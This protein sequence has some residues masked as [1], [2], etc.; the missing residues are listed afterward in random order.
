MKDLSQFRQSN[1]Y[2]LCKFAQ[3]LNGLA[4]PTVLC[5]WAEV[6]KLQGLIHYIHFERTVYLK[7]VTVNTLHLFNLYDVFFLFLWLFFFFFPFCGLVTFT[8]F[9]YNPP[10][11][12]I[13]VI[14][15]AS[16]NLFK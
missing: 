4:L 5:L 16:C 15:A 6:F 14:G 9:S 1:G 10:P 8:M 2:C 12:D 13:R 3:W 11:H 7:A